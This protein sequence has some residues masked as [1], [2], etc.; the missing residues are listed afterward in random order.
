MMTLNRCSNLS[1][2]ATLATGHVRARCELSLDSMAR[3]LPHMPPAQHSPAASPPSLP[4]VH[5]P[6]PISSAQGSCAC[7]RTAPAPHRPAR[8]ATR[9]R[10][11]RCRRPSSLT[12]SRQR[13]RASTTSPREP[14]RRR[15]RAACAGSRRAHRGQLAAQRALVAVITL[16]LESRE[17]GVSRARR[18]KLHLVDLAGSESL[19][20]E[21]EALH[22]SHETRAI[23]SALTALCDVMQTLSKNARRAQ[24]ARRRWCRTATTS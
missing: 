21:K 8:A 22:I 23:N 3:S 17:G 6:P 16:A 11:R 19:V 10:C 13:A 12:T 5:S 15:T 24:A 2:R 14:R 18:G 1:L 20:G 9:R 7:L 4:C